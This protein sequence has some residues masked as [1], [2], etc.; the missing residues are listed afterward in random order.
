MMLGTLSP[1]QGT[2]LLQQAVHQGGLAMVPRAIMAILRSFLDQGVTSGH[3]PVQKRPADYTPITF[4]QGYVICRFGRAAWRS[5]AL[6]TPLTCRRSTGP[7]P[8]TV[9]TSMRASHINRQA[10]RLGQ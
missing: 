1:V 9:L 8:A 10:R 5:G 6:S 3:G 4:S 2:G 7:R